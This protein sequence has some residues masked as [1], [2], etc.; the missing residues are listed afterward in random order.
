M[1]PSGANRRSIGANKTG[2]TAYFVSVGLALN[3]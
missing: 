1:L 3:F 2:K